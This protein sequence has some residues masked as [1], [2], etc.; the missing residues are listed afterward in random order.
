MCQPTCTKGPSSTV[1]VN[2][3]HDHGPSS[4]RERHPSLPDPC[5]SPE[6]AKQ[7]SRCSVTHQLKHSESS[8]MLAGRDWRNLSKSAVSVLTSS[9]T[10]VILCG[11]FTVTIGATSDTFKLCPG[12]NSQGRCLLAM[13]TSCSRLRL[14]RHCGRTLFRFVH[15]LLLWWKGQRGCLTEP[16]HADLSWA[17]SHS[18]QQCTHTHTTTARELAQLGPFFFSVV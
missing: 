10:Y 12:A 14:C 7:L 6:R 13:Q 9:S 1:R 8:S 18:C 11:S 17:R 4:L 5:P 16:A 3:S 2:S 15:G